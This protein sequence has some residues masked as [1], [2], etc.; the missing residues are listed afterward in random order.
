MVFKQRMLFVVLLANI[1]SLFAQTP[2]LTKNDSIVKSSWIIGLGYHFVDDS[3]DVFNNLLD[4]NSSWNAVPYPSRIS[5]GKYFENGLGVEFIGAY[6]R[7]D[8][9]NRIDKQNLSGVKDF[10][11]AD[12]RLSYDLNEIL[13]DTGWFDPYLGTGLG[14]TNANS[15]SRVTANAVVGFRTWFSD[16][17][18]LDINASGKWS[19]SPNATNYKQY[20]A[21]IVYRFGSKKELTTEGQEKLSLIEKL[22]QEKINDSI[23][24]A[25]EQ[26]KAF[27]EKLAIEKE[28]AKQS[29][30][31]KEKQIALADERKKVEN[32]IKALDKINFNFSSAVIKTESKNTIA[33]LAKILEQYPDLLIEISSH[34]DSR[35]SKAYNQILSEKRL[36]ATIDYLLTFDVNSDNISGKAFGEEKLLNECD[37][38]TKCSE[39]KHQ[40]NRRSEIKILDFKK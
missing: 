19:L 37:D 36:K 11:S 16:K 9:G 28:K 18:G 13:G 25:T 35:G 22:E 5:I 31:E 17:I 6:S 10:F 32:S 29:Q 4:F 26:E 7:Y 24:L 14:F 38:S 8:S 39:D 40:E 20:A 30:I 27:Q 1:Y 23:N 33:R 2:V 12:A 34:T 21:G 3:G 15:K